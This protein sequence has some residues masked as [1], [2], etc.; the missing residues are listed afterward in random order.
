[1]RLLFVLNRMAHVRHFDRTVKILAD[2]GHEIC[3]A[4][5]DDELALPGVLAKHPRI[6][7]T[8]AARNRGDDWTAAASM[9]RRTRD[10]IRYLHPR[11]G[12]ARLLRHRAFE[13]MVGSVSDR[14]E[15]LDATW[16]ELLLRMPKPEQKRLDALLAKLE[17]AIPC[18]PD[19]EAFVTAQS[20]DAIVLS[21]MVGVGFTQADFVKS[22]RALGI[23]S[24]LLVFS[25][26]NLSNKGLIHEMPDRMFVWN[27]IQVREA[28]KLHK[29]PADRVVVTGA[30][31]FDEFFEMKPATTR[32]AFCRMTGLDATRPIVTYLCSSKFVAAGEQTFVSRWISELRQSRDPLLASS[33]LIVRPHPAGGKGWHG[34]DAF[35]LRWP[36]VAEKAT[37]S[38]P[39]GDER[40]LVMNSPMQNADAVLFD[41]VFHSAAVVGLNTSAEIE[42]AIVGRPVFTIV[43]SNAGGQEGTLHFHYLLRSQG[44]HVELAGGF[45]QHR[46]QL[47][48]ALAGGSDRSRIDAFVERFVRPRGLN[49]PVAPIVAEAIEALGSPDRD[50]IGAVRG[51]VL[52][53]S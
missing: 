3:L 51:T 37:V 8:A 27:D 32:E 2:R 25:W 44:G 34:A 52:T 42:A 19:I 7:S 9:L 10:Y 33:S 15:A 24:G 22:A 46:D 28:V 53:E 23:P 1:M 5:Q 12:S 30:P 35:D 40:A 16:S 14:A 39:F 43:D 18:D 29:Y 21:P 4:S 45:D 47:S 49:F 17:T 48:A 20:P 38:R 41:T 36:L 6:T 50:R 11:Y 31:R 13:K 26:D